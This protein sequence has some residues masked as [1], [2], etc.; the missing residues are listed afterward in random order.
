LQVPLK[1][2]ELKKLPLIPNTGT[3]LIKK[4]VLTDLGL[5]NNII[6]LE[7]GEENEIDSDEELSKSI[8]KKG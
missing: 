8:I 7:E 6:T 2:D 1:L 3:R 5:R 4:K